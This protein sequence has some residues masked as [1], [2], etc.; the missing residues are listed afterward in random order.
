MNRFI[1]LVVVAL[2]CF[3]AAPLFSQTIL[4]WD[5]DHN[6]KFQDPEGAGLVDPTYGITKALDDNGFSYDVTT[7]TNPDLTG[8]DTLFVVMGIYC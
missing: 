5:K 8:Y 4:V 6:K 7:L 1:P 3:V 2:L